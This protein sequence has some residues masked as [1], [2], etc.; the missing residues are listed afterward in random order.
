MNLVVETSV[1][2]LKG[3]LQNTLFNQLGACFWRRRLKQQNALPKKLILLLSWNFIEADERTR[4]DSSALGLQPCLLWLFR[5]PPRA[6][7][8]IGGGLYRCTHDSSFSWAPKPPFLPSHVPFNSRDN[9]TPFL[10]K[11]GKIYQGF[12]DFTAF[13]QEFFDHTT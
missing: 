12:K 7:H 4:R 1:L 10:L 2:F 3:K 13:I 9:R 5:E 11:Q 8:L 6:V